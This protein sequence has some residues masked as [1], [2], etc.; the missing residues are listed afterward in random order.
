MQRRELFGSLA[1]PFKNR[2]LQ[3]KAIRPPY[4]KDINKN[5]KKCLECLDKPCSTA[6]EENI[7]EI[8][9]KKKKKITKRYIGI[10]EEEISETLLNFRL[11]F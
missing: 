10:N 3:E 9:E 1:K 8:L 5:K 6:C 11:G 2:S 4:F 7:I